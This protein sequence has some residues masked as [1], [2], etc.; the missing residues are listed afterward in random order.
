VPE[1]LVI[2]LFPVLL[3]YGFLSDGFFV[4]CWIW[5]LVVRLFPILL[6][7]DF[8]S[9]GFLWDMLDSA[10]GLW[11]SRWRMGWWMIPFS[12]SELAS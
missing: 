10:F 5:F 2:R 8:M 1:E 9:D 7:Y 6:Y 12:G 4:I 11:C 3:C